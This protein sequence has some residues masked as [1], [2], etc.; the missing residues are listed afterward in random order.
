MHAARVTALSGLPLFI[1]IVDDGLLM[2]AKVG[3]LKF[4]LVEVGEG[5]G[6]KS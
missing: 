4:V 5:L 2:G 1:D 6:V 3:V